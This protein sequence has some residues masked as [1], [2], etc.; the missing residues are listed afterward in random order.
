[1][2]TADVL[3]QTAADM[4]AATAQNLPR[5]RQDRGYDY[6]AGWAFARERVADR[7][8]EQADLLGLATVT[9][10]TCTRLAAA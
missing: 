6:A 7:L 2:N 5:V 10:I 1:M 3:R 9:P 4:R 8:I